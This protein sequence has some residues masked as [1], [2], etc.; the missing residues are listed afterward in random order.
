[1][2]Q[3]ASSS[4][5]STRRPA[6]KC[7][8]WSWPA[9]GGQA[10]Q[11]PPLPASA[12]LTAIGEEAG[13]TR[14]RQSPIVSPARQYA[15][16]ADW[17]ASCT[18]CSLAAQAARAHLVREGAGH[19]PAGCPGPPR[20]RMRS[21]SRFGGGGYHVAP[22]GPLHRRPPGCPDRAPAGRGARW[23]GR[24]VK[25]RGHCTV[26]PR[27][28]GGAA[29]GVCARGW[30][31]VSLPMRLIAA[32]AGV[33]SSSFTAASAAAARGQQLRPPPASQPPATPAPTGAEARCGSSGA[34][35][36]SGRG[37][38]PPPPARHA[39]P[40]AQQHHH[41]QH[42]PPS[43]LLPASSLAAPLLASQAVAGL[44]APAGCGRAAAWASASPGGRRPFPAEAAAAAPLAAAHLP[45]SSRGLIDYALAPRPLPRFRK[46]PKQLSWQRM[47]VRIPADVG[48]ALEGR[49]L[50]FAG[51]GR[52]PRA[53]RGW[54]GWAGR[55]WWLGGD[56]G[57]GVRGGGCGDRSH[58][59]CTHQPLPMAHQRAVPTS[60]ILGAV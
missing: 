37:V 47:V 9:A 50:Q 52:L 4:T 30:W 19:L 59:A 8:A 5:V 25:R 7:E 21:H 11:S 56:A 60:C 45:S 24:R 23:G 1:M 20:H 16:C 53:G 40:S 43:L 46:V 13:D 18:L 39:R 27:A 48:V 17:L 36:C 54:L 55:G 49:Q 15:R 14:A 34:A 26:R 58:A 38:P 57:W 44:A 22:L 12:S 10:A 35:S 2:R 31:G 51:A 6:G 41:Q 28:G 33:S 42:R 3:V 29:R 32:H